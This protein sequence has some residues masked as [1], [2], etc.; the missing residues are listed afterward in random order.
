MLCHAWKYYGK[1]AFLYKLDER[2]D[3]RRLKFAV[4]QL[5]E[6][7]PELKAIIQMAEGRYQIIRDD[8]RKIDIPIVRLSNVQWEENEKRI[9]VSVPLRR[10]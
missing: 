4:E 6:V 1:S 10:G 2:T 5:F 8:K 9:A 7:H 3:L